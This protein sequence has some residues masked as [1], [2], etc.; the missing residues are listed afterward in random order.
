LEL[1]LQILDASLDLCQSLLKFR[2]DLISDTLGSICFGGWGFSSAIYTGRFN[3]RPLI[4]ST[5]QQVGLPLVLQTAADAATARMHMIAANFG[6]TTGLTSGER[7]VATD[8]SDMAR[9]N[10]QTCTFSY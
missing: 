2:F 6:F 9:H 1:P 10:D 4:D 7:Q 3:T 5:L 8:F